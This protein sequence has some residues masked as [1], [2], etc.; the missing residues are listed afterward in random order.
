ML[1]PLKWLLSYTDLKINTTEESPELQRE[2][3]LT[4]TM[5]Q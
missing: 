1:A 5:V 3:T 4:G 2:L